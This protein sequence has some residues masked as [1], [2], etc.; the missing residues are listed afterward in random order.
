[1]SPHSSAHQDRFAEVHAAL[2]A[3]Q[4]AKRVLKQ[5]HRRLESQGAKHQLN[6][7]LADVLKRTPQEE[8]A[9]V[10]KTF[11]EQKHTC[12]KRRRSNSTCD[13]PHAEPGAGSSTNVH[14]MLDKPVNPLITPWAAKRADSFCTE[15]VLTRWVT[16]INEEIGVA[17]CS[18][19]IWAARENLQQP[20][21]VG[22]SAII[23][24]TPSSRRHRQQWVR[25]WRRRW[26]LRLGH[27]RPGTVLCKEDLR[28]KALFDVYV[29]PPKKNREPHFG[30]P[31]NPFLRKTRGHF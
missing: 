11:Q 12:R 24:P 4:H 13:D 19:H 1:M 3:V 30:I 8:H 7:V 20:G 21:S 15:S 18:A 9:A 25:R 27:Y 28:K 26:L 29:K 10:A 6:F 5:K 23:A 17:P 14:Q 2:A 16:D 31:M 22:S